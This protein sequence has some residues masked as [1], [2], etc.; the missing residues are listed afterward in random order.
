[1]QGAQSVGG[2]ATLGQGWQRIEEGAAFHEHFME[3]NLLRELC[4]QLVAELV[5][6]EQLN[7]RVKMK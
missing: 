4:S 3:L 1:M 6:L 7:R 5:E 2:G